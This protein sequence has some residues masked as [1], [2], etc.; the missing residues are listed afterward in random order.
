MTTQVTVSIALLTL[1]L[2]A[3]TFQQTL[4]SGTDNPCAT[5]KEIVADYPAE[6][7]T[8][9][10]GGSN[11][12]SVTIYQAKEELIKGHCEVWAWGNAD[13]AYVCTVGAPDPEVA[14]TRYTNAVEQVSSCIGPEWVSEEEGR[15]IDGN[16]A[17]VVTHF[18]HQSKGMPLVSVHNVDD[19]WRRSVYLYIGSP[20]RTF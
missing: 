8:F 14:T 1:S 17:G 6:F 15:E 9:R 11:F 5:L 2:S 19:R 18:R 12:R 3:C 10:N 4:E 13:S 7:A 16:E 20:A